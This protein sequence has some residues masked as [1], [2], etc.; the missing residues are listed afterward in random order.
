MAAL[1]LL[2]AFAILINLL[3]IPTHKIDYKL[4]LVAAAVVATILFFTQYTGGAI[5]AVVAVLLLL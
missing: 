3:R 4:R 5:L 1:G 2:V